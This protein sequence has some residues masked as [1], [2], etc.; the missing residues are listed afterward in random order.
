MQSTRSP[1]NAG[2]FQGIEL[3][4]SQKAALPEKDGSF[5]QLGYCG[6]PDPACKVPWL[7]GRRTCRGQCPQRR[8]LSSLNS[9]DSTSPERVG[10]GLGI[11]GTNPQGF[12]CRPSRKQ[13]ACQT[14]CGVRPQHACQLSCLKLLPRSHTQGYFRHGGCRQPTVLV[15][16]SAQPP[17]RVGQVLPLR[18]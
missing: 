14:K 6:F 12:R 17:S 10:R 7:K 4:R 15:E 3:R 11:V 8:P 13:L 16:R 5:R 9:Q 1:E 18:F 2:G